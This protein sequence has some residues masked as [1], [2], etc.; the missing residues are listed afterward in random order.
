MPCRAAVLCCAPLIEDL[1]DVLS[2][3][4]PLDPMQVAHLRIISRDG[5]GP[6][7]CSGRSS[8]LRYALELISAGIVADD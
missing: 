1:S 8:E 2:G 5:A 7:Y 4:L 3:D 6:L